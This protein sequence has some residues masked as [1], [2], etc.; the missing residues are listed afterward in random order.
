MASN[1][2]Q[3]LLQNL[4]KETIG[5]IFSHAKMFTEKPQL[6]MKW[7]CCISSPLIGQRNFSFDDYDSL[8]RE[9]AKLEKL[10][11]G[12]IHIYYGYELPVF[13]DSSG[14]NLFLV[15]IDGNEV[16]LTVGWHERRPINA[17]E[18]G[19]ATEKVNLDELI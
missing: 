2:T 16:P 12:K 17:G 14:Y 10:T 7:H 4:D 13:T 6:V 15:D 19:V 3:E 18:F 8:R 11:L 1:E 5:S 9:L